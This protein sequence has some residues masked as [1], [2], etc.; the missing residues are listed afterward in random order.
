MSKIISLSLIIFM[1]F[2]A[3]K[4]DKKV[5]EPLK[6]EELKSINQK[7]EEKSSNGLLEKFSWDKISES[8]SEIGAFPYI[9][10]P[11]NMI[12]NEN[13]SESY[14]FDKLEFFNGANFFVLD[15]KVKRMKVEMEGQKQFEKYYFEKSVSEYLKSIGAVLIFDG[16]MTTEFTSKWGEDPNSIYDHMH[17]FYSGDV[18]NYPVSL[19]LLKTPNKKIGFQ[20]SSSSKSI[21][22]VEQKVFEQTIEK[23]TA[24]KMINDINSQGYV[25]LS[26]NFD[27][28]KSRIKAESYEII[29]EI[30]K[31][32]KSNPDLKI[33]IEGHTDNTGDENT[34]LKL[35]NNRAKSVLIAL[36]D[37]GIDESRLTSKGFG[38]TKPIEDNSTEDDRA[39]NRRVELRKI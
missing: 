17:E 8:N 15:G 39:K 1:A 3:Y 20:V 38:Q 32:L 23:I 18:V 10:P 34:N 19:Y 5:K 28:G 36:L 27:M 14:E 7:Q 6:K 22:V 31:M 24:D 12:V 26:I 37:E 25:S 13:E 29:N 2:V 16:Q 21:G 33:S 4:N 11:K 30:S 35:S 9:T